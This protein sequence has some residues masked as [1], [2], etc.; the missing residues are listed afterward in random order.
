MKLRPAALFSICAFI[1]FCVF[2][3]MA[4]DWRMQA[5]LYPW[6]IGIPMLVLAIVQVILDL[7]GVTAKQSADATPMDFQFTKDVD[8][9][10]ARKRAITMFAWL[11]G[12]FFAIWLLGFPIAIALMMFTYLK[13][14]GGE[15]WVL[16]IT[17]TI[18]AWLF[19]YSLFVRLLNLPFPD[20][21]LMTW[22]G[23][24]A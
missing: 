24:N 11:V 7:K 22:L 19:F 23:W 13:F 21:L 5:R 16:S 9:T 1:F 12:F 2:V 17:L 14:Q 8:A 6:A 18:I 20:G 10:T 4:Q 3:Y 15:S